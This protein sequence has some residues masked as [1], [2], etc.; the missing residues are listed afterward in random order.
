MTV[1]SDKK[2]AKDEIITAW[3]QILNQT[4]WDVRLHKQNVKLSSG[5]T[6]FDCTANTIQCQSD[7]VPQFSTQI[8]VYIV[9]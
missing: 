6:F 2:P 7:Q 8:E 3:E 4:E 5:L 1:L 9:D